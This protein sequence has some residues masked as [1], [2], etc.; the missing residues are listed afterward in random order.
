MPRRHVR[1]ACKDTWSNRSARENPLQNK[2]YISSIRVRNKSQMSRFVVRFK[3]DGIP[4]SVNSPFSNTTSTVIVRQS[5]SLEYREIGRRFSPLWQVWAQKLPEIFLEQHTE[6]HT[7]FRPL[8]S[9][10]KYSIC[11]IAG[12]EL[13][14]QFPSLPQLDTNCS[15]SFL[16]VLSVPHISDD[17]WQQIVIEAS[18][19]AQNRAHTS[20]PESPCA[21]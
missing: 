9:V 18:A 3:E 13:D 1:L 2:N 19:A 7:F 14:C 8:I 21:S 10:P 6:F 16:L 4:Q 17:I 11:L 12:V 20:T 15:V 5:R